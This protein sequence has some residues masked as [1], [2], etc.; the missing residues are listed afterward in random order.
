M[1]YGLIVYLHVPDLLANIR[2]GWKG[3]LE[4]TLYLT[5]QIC[6]L[7]RKRA[8]PIKKFWN[9]F[10]HTVLQAHIITREKSFQLVNG[11]AYKKE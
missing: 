6:R 4:P 8:N 10:T 2:L 1:E 3:L 11:P 7:H 5:A 9:K